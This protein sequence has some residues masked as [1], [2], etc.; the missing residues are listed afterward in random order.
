MKDQVTFSA[1]LIRSGHLRSR[2]RTTLRIVAATLTVGEVVVGYICFR[3]ADF[4]SAYAM[5]AYLAK[6]HFIA[7]VM[8][9]G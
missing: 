4:L 9:D 6:E 3:R 7:R 5:G 2:T 8:G 1:A